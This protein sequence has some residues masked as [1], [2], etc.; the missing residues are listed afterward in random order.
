M[1]VLVY[2]IPAIMELVM[3]VDG[4]V[5]SANKIFADYYTIGKIPKDKRPSTS[6]NCALAQ[7]EGTWGRFC[8]RGCVMSDGRVR[9][10]LIVPQAI[11]TGY[12]TECRISYA[13]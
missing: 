10:S 5:D 6:V 13:F 4:N 7:Y 8:A 11:H 3:R 1:N 2:D 12:T 9:L